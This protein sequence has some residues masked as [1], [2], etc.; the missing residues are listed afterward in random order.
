MRKALSV[1]LI[2]ILAFALACNGKPTGVD[3][4]IKDVTIVLTK[5]STKY[6]F[7]VVNPDVK[8]KAEVDEVNWIIVNPL[9]LPLTEVR[10]HKFK[11]RN[12]GNKD[13]FDNGGEFY[14]PSVPTG[15]QTPDRLSGV[16]KHI[17]IYD[18][19]VTGTLMLSSGLVTVTL[20]PM[21]RVSDVR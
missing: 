10:I 2:S 11:G 18:Y 6:Q 15:G 20:D 14:Y 12:T 7:I 5:Q 16:S 21:V 9:D 1:L 3:R 17:D 13:P 19:E 8:I 4:V